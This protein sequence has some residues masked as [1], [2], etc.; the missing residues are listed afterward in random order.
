MKTLREFR[1]QYSINESASTLVG[2]PS[3]DNHNYTLSTNHV[4][5]GQN[6]TAHTHIDD[7]GDLHHQID[8]AQGNAVHKHHSY[9]DKIGRAH[10]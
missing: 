8:D 9:R 2:H 1:S 4:H 5:N 10:V 7:D 3:F 6:Y